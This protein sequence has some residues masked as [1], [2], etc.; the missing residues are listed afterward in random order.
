M[1]IYIAVTFREFDGSEN[2]KI[3]VLFLKS[4]MEQSYQN[5]ELIVTTFEEKTVKDKL[6]SL[7][8]SSRIYEEKKLNY[9]FSLTKV[10]DNAIHYAD[11]ECPDKNYFIIWT[12]CDIVFE[13]NFLENVYRLNKLSKSKASIISHPHLIHQNVD[14]LIAEKYVIHGPNDGIDYIGFSG[15]LITNNFKLDISKYF[16]SDWGVFEHYLVAMSVKYNFDRLNIFEISKGR[17]IANDRIVNNEN[18]Q[19]FAMSLNKNWPVFKTFLNDSNL[20]REYFSLAY[21]NLKFRVVGNLFSNFK[22]RIKYTRSYLQY[23]INYII[24]TIISFIPN[25]LKDPLKKFLKGTKV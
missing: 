1:K 2:D 13:D 16:Y 17:K 12:T 21:C 5:F 7:S 25:T 9:R 3:Q 19:Y 15:K 23:F 20:S 24:R 8:I 4:L 6:N 10:L 18:E 14:D 11:V 22:Y